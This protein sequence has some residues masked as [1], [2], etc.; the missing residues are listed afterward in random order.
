MAKKKYL[1]LVFNDTTDWKHYSLHEALYDTKFSEPYWV[2]SKPLRVFDDYHFAVDTW[3]KLSKM[4]SQV[5][6][7]NYS[8]IEDLFNKLEYTDE[9]ELEF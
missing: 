5:D 7:L 4:S 3:A 2:G 1:Q 6:I 9:I 8:E